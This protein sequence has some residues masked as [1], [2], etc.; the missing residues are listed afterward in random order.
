MAAPVIHYTFDTDGTNS[1]SYPS[2][3]ITTIPSDITFDSSNKLIGDK[4]ISI[5]STSPSASTSSDGSAASNRTIVPTWTTPNNFTISQW[6]KM[7]TFKGRGQSVIDWDVGSSGGFVLCFWNSATNL[8][9]YHG[10]V[11]TVTVPNVFDNEYHHF[12]CTITPTDVTVYVDNVS[13]G[14]VSYTTVTNQSVTKTYIG[15]RGN[16]DFCTSGYIDDFRVYDY[17]TDLTMIDMI[18]KLGKNTDVA[19]LS[20]ATMSNLQNAGATLSQLVTAGISIADLLAAGVTIAQLVAANVTIPQLVAAGFTATELSGHFTQTQID[21]ALANIKIQSDFTISDGTSSS[22]FVAEIISPNN[23]LNSPNVFAST[24][25]KTSTPQKWQDI[26]ISSTGQYQIAVVGGGNYTGTWHSTTINTGNVWI[27]TDYGETWL[28]KTGADQVSG[29][30]QQWISAMVSGDGSV[31][32]VKGRGNLLYRSTDSGASWANINYTYADITNYGTAGTAKNGIPMKMASDGT[33]LFTYYNAGGSAGSPNNTFIKSIDGGS[34]WTQSTTPDTTSNQI[35]TLNSSKSGQYIILTFFDLSTVA[36][37][38][39]DYGETFIKLSNVA[40]HLQTNWNS[41]HSYVA[42]ISNTGKICTNDGTT[43]YNIDVTTGTI[44]GVSPNQENDAVQNISVAPSLLVNSWKYIMNSSND[45]K[46]VMFSGG[47]DFTILV[48]TDYGVTFNAMDSTSP[49][50]TTAINTNE[51]WGC[52]FSDDNKYIAVAQNNYYIYVRKNTTIPSEAY[53]LPTFAAKLT[54]DLTGNTVTAGGD[55]TTTDSTPYY[56]LY[57]QFANAVTLTNMP[58]DIF[59]IPFSDFSVGAGGQV[60]LRNVNLDAQMTIGVSYTSL[61]SQIGSDIFGETANDWCGS[62]TSLNADGTIVAVLEPQ[63]DNSNTGSFNGRVRIFQ[64]KIPTT[65]EW[66]TANVVIKGDDTTQGA[67][68]YWTQLGGHINTA[69]VH[70]SNGDGNVSLSSDGTTVAICNIRESTGSNVSVFERNISNTTIEPIGWTQIGGEIVETLNSACSLNQDGTVL[71]VGASSADFPVKN[72]G[73]V[74]V[75]ERNDAKTEAVTD[76]TQLNYG[77]VGWSGVGQRIL[78]PAIWAHFGQDCAL[79]SNGRIVAGGAPSLDGDYINGFVMLFE[80]D[81]TKVAEVTDESQ[82]NYGPVGWNRVGERINGKG[83]SNKDNF[84]QSLGLSADG[85]I[86]A[87]GAAYLFSGTDGDI[88]KGYVQVYKY[89]IP[90]ATEWSSVN[91][92]K[93]IDTTQTDMNKYYWTQLGQDID[94]KTVGDRFGAQVRL[95]ADGYSVAIGSIKDLNTGLSYVRVYQYMDATNNWEIIQHI[96]G[97]EESANYYAYMS[98]SADGSTLS[99]GEKYYDADNGA[100]DNCGRVRIYELPVK[101]ANTSTIPAGNNFINN[102]VNTIETD[103]VN[104]TLSYDASNALIT[105]D[106]LTQDISMSI[107]STDATIFDTS[108][109]EITVAANTLPFITYGQPDPTFANYITN[110]MTITELLTVYTVAQLVAGGVSVSGLLS[111]NVTIPELLAANVT[112]AQLLASNIVVEHT[113][114]SDY[115]KTEANDYNGTGTLPSL[116]PADTE[117]PVLLQIESTIHTMEH[118]DG[119]QINVEFYTS[120]D[121]KIGNTEILQTA[122]AR[123]TTYT[124]NFS[125]PFIYSDIKVKLVAV[126]TDGTLFTQVKITFGSQVY[127]WSVIGTDYSNPANNTV[128]WVD[129]GDSNPESRTYT[130]ITNDTH[131]WQNTPLVLTDITVD[132]LD[133]ITVIKGDLF[134]QYFSIIP[135]TGIAEYTQDPDDNQLNGHWLLGVYVEASGM[136]TRTAEIAFILDGTTPAIQLQ[137]R[138]VTNIGYD[139]TVTDASMVQIYDD[140]FSD[141]TTYRD[142]VASHLVTNLVFTVSTPITIATLLAANV[143]VPQL[144]A[145]N[146]TV[147]GL[148]SANVTIPELL[149][150]NVTVPELIAANVTAAQIFAAGVSITE[151]IAAGVVPDWNMDSDANHFVQSYVKDFIDISGSLLLRENA[152]LTVN[153]NIE[154]KGNITIKNPIMAADVSL[155]HRIFV[156]GD[157]SM[158]GN[159]TVG[160]VSMNGTVIDCSFVDLSIPESAING[161][162]G[163][164]YT[165]PTI[166]YEKGFDTTADISMNANVQINNLKVDGNIE[167]SDGTTMD[168]Y[169]DNIDITFIQETLQSNLTI[170]HGSTYVNGGVPIQCSENGKY[171]IVHFGDI[172]TTNGSSGGN[173]TRSAILLSSNYGETYNVITLPSMAA[174]DSTY[175][176][177]TTEN[178]FT[179][180]N[181]ICMGI[182]PSGQ[183]IIIGMSGTESHINNWTDASIAWSL[184]YGVTWT[185]NNIKQ[186]LTVPYVS[187]SLFP[188]SCAIDDT[189]QIAIAIQIS[190]QYTSSSARGIYYSSDRTTFSQ[191]SYFPRSLKLYIINNDI[192]FFSSTN[193]LFIKITFAGVLRSVY[194]PSITNG[195]LKYSVSQST[196]NVGIC[197]VATLGW[198]STATNRPCYFIRD[199]GTTLTATDMTSTTNTV[200]SNNKYE[201]MASA[202]SLSGKYIM[203][204]A[205]NGFIGGESANDNINIREAVYYSEDYGATFDM[206]T[207]ITSQIASEIASEIFNIVITDNGY[208]YIYLRSSSRSTVRLKFVSFK[209]STF[210]SLIIS[211]TLTAGSFSTSSDYRIKTDV[212]QLDETITLDNLRPVK[213]LQT[214][215]NK[216]QYGLIAHELQEYYPDLVVGEKD[217]DEMQ[218]VNYTGLVAILIHEIKQLKQELTELEN[219]VQ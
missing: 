37:Y 61:L 45:G 98:L 196:S 27:S 125:I 209:S 175:T 8:L 103:L 182:S 207:I 86:V 186:L 21:I 64:F 112:V 116:T 107:T 52:R 193:Y 132:S 58:K 48:S 122:F 111:A 53:T 46:Y 187:W 44:T 176:S 123:D 138:G 13:C 115:L 28:E 197:A 70:S 17:A 96:D 82:S 206:R 145:A 93:G 29:S 57:L 136:R 47:M 35:G 129:Y 204:G 121:V 141:T 158:N 200:L 133:Q 146:V 153:G 147:S 66:D 140:P 12:L 34:S 110:G 89:K 9:I 215:L 190:N 11:K 166:I 62:S 117:Q 23:P 104:Y 87:G 135:A 216:P 127:I 118:A 114:S 171:S 168:T 43:L 208:I 25:A 159:V 195:Y 76:S 154:T 160:D 42:C 188:T 55:L 134:G 31:M 97:E 149:A 167:F 73:R 131:D 6:M 142:D 119:G 77:P 101:I 205:C 185:T 106:G 130:G 69:G 143:T 148:L 15:S 164:D 63:Y 54:T 156:G 194:M 40:S 16:T 2:L 178:D 162:Y 30:V 174:I 126:S 152:S 181:F 83:R 177:Y 113:L 49:F 68:K 100:T 39:A 51:V 212:S 92:A 183:N 180:V 203:V 161:T 179:K 139:L 199:D 157:V 71:T 22:V 128:G 219:E 184:D 74:R 99:Y 137:Y 150:A 169:D 214:L 108:M 19:S 218:R 90:T 78:G 5:F 38:S 144:V 81:D 10:A 217:G 210:T 151:L 75:F 198:Q 88:H 120:N 41:T 170:T 95:S 14:S 50:A 155:N 172:Y 165:Q 91:I 213:Y 79:S 124:N 192:V 18:Y 3:D 80:R 36:M 20:G 32:M 105:L 202:M 26:E 85:T 191:T 102:F 72:T 67:G 173:A 109:T 33:T 163:P 201:R 4:C 24:D 189:G 1:G 84:G 94:G 7:E 60:N 65:T 56:R 59:N 211:N